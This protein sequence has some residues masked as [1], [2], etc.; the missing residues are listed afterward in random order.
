MSTAIILCGGLGTR[1][2]KIFPEVPKSLVN[3]NG[4][5][6]LFYILDYL[7][8]QDIDNV[9]LSIGYK[10]HDIITKIPKNYQ[11]LKISFSQEETL[12]GTGGAVIKA[13][14]DFSIDNNFFILNGDTYFPIDLHQMIKYHTEKKADLTLGMTPV[15]DTKRFGRI[16][17][18]LDGK[19]KCITKNIIGLGH[20][21][22]GVYFCHA[23]DFIHLE[24]RNCNLE[25]DII[26]T[27]ISNKK[28]IYCFESSASFV[29]IGTEEG[30]LE[31]LK[32]VPKEK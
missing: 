8:S 1:L 20:I 3:I 31:S 29:D 25:V 22:G 26:E 23:R 12:L 21:N 11:N 2:K 30:W 27:L 19:I 6:F 18:H 15:E 24:V 32:I 7:K 17:I 28:L 9:I 13:V 14:K 4:R 10:A 16:E 5:P